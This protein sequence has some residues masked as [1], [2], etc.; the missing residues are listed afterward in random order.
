MNKSKE[1]FHNKLA[2]DRIPEHLAL[3][4]IHCHTRILDDQEYETALSKKLEEETLEYLL[5]KDP[6]HQ[7][8]ELADILEVIHAILKNKGIHYSELDE[9]RVAK[10]E[11][12]GGFEHR[13]YLEKTIT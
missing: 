9:V 11:E 5:A 12:K 2:R 4:G 10:Y 8:E 1:V 3:K 13:I 6:S 7:L